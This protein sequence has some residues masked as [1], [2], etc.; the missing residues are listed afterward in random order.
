MLAASA[1]G[2]LATY[3]FDY[4]KR[5]MFD[6]W[7]NSANDLE[8]EAVAYAIEVAIAD[9]RLRPR[10]EGM[11]APWFRNREEP[12][13]QATA[14]RAHGAALAPGDPA[15]ALAALDRLAIVDRFVVASAIGDSL[16]DYV[17]RAGVDGLLRVYPMLRRWLTDRERRSTGELA[18]LILADSLV[19]DPAGDYAAPRWPE[20]LHLASQDVRCREPLFALWRGVIEYGTFHD[21]TGEVLTSWARSAENDDAML[22]AYVR[23]VRATA[24]GSRPAHRFLYRLASDWDDPDELRPLFKAASEVRSV[25][26]S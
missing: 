6:A 19:R 14:A 7:A 17:V 23:M 13:M 22:D 25:L 4:V 1:V 15:K 18:F 16:A 5:T 8:R 24:G 26:Q 9:P 12:A 2:R 3:G 10:A 21:L 11:V 20:L